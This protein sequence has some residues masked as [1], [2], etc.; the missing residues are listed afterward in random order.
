MGYEGWLQGSSCRSG[1]CCREVV[2]QRPF[3]HANPDRAPKISANRSLTDI[4]LKA[5]DELGN[6]KH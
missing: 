3:P 6:T 2:E 5:I 1:F 4:C